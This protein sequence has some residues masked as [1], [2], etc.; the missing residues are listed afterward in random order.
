MVWWGYKAMGKAVGTGAKVGAK[1]GASLGDSLA[2]KMALHSA[3]RGARR[4][5]LAPGDP[6]PPP[7]AT[8]DYLDYRGVAS[9]PEAQNLDDGQFP[10]GAFSDL[11]KGKFR[12]PIGLPGEVINRHAVVVGPA[13][14]GKTFSLLI[15]WMYAA[16]MANWSVVA[17][18]VK[19]DLRE[20]F[21]DFKDAQGGGALGARL[22]KW[23]FTDPIRS[24]PW[25]WL[26]ELHDDAR[27]DAAI[28]ALLGRRPEQSTGDPYFYQRDYRT[29]RGLL[30]FARA[31]A[32]QARTASDL[33]R[34]LEDDIK[35]D[36]AVKQHARAPGV[37]DLEA[38]LR[39]PQADYPKIISGVVTALSALDSSGVNAVTRA[40][41]KRPSINLEAALDDHQLLIVGAALKGGQVSATLS[42]LLLNQLSQR[43][44]ERFGQK[45]RP[46]L[47][48]IDEAPQ[49]VDRV[50]IAKLM[51]VS[52]SAGVGVVVAMQDVAQIK[53]ENDRSSILSN[54][55]AFAILPGASPKSVDEFG[56][57]LGQR[58]ERTVGMNV[59]GPRSGFG[60]PTPTQT[61]GTE[62]VPVLR[63]R[64]IMQPPFGGRAAIVHVKAQ[65]L[66]VTGK[67]LLVDMQ[68]DG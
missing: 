52:R 67:P 11:A 35:L 64:E 19:G 45:R 29:L 5:Y 46:V 17:V 47:L 10:L 1:T 28:T 4:G 54:A 63:E 36:A 24:S 22:T 50:D 57:R 16:L 15:P 8:T 6:T 25:Q 43:L 37:A 13:G 62:A 41:S 14:S 44:Y 23:D 30:L 34:L 40:T 68:R 51:E 59:G 9:W 42:S 3:G 31:A 18:D 27:V 12:G 66:G 56:K 7:T 32:P 53:D 20:D 58:F 48:V 55:A 2:S 21:L 33:I 49:I 38:A 60:A 26:G 61:L 65:E 39:F